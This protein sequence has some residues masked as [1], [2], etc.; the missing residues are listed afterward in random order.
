[1]NVKPLFPASRRA[2]LNR[3][4]EFVPHAG[5][6]YTAGRNTDAGPGRRS[7]IS[8]LS[9]YIRYRL[10]SEREVIA[11]VLEQHPNEQA[12]KF[13]QEVCWRTYWKGW[14]Q[15]RPQVWFDFLDERDR[16]RSS[17]AQHSGLNKALSGAEAGRTGI[18]CFDDWVHELIETGYLHNH[19]RMWFA[20]IW[21][22]TLKLSWALGAD[23]FLRHLIDADPAS[24]TLSWRWVAGIQTRGKTY[25]AR[26]DNIAKYTNGRYQPTGLATQAVPIRDEAPYVPGAIAPLKP[27]PSGAR[28][29]LLLHAEDFSGAEALPAAIRPLAAVVTASTVGQ[30]EWPHGHH[31]RSFVQAAAHECAQSTGARFEQAVEVADGFDADQL[32]AQAKACG[33]DLIIT[34]DAPVGSI[35]TA[36]TELAASL[37]AR[38]LALVRYRRDWDREAWPRANKG[39]FPFKKSIPRLLQHAGLV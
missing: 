37:E 24:N 17:A 38:G 1:M 30:N 14:L 36:L 10:I 35:D 12:E 16:D 28:A 19:T 39:F 25:L 33:A 5:R 13:I 26:P 9:P 34:P 8:M 11:A 32:A 7:Q 29:L 20:S 3:L 27:I 31:A 21:I 2:G 15:M 23:F 6:A 18:E 4:A 22:F